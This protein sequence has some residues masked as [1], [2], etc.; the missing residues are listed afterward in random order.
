[1]LQIKEQCYAATIEEKQ[2]EAQVQ[3]KLVEAL[4][5]KVVDL[6]GNLDEELT[7][8]N[9]PEEE[10]DAS[11]RAWREDPRNVGQ[12][13]SARRPEALFSELGTN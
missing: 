4:Q 5:K 3:K 13:K 10:K 7:K 6:G 11:G 8:E 1:M 2:R 12:G 9:Q